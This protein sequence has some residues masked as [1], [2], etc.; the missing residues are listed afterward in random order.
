[1]SHF[2]VSPGPGGGSAA[3]VQIIKKIPVFE[4]LSPNQVQQV[5]S[6]CV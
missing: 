2:Q 5:L 4:Q 1:M 6:I 3:L